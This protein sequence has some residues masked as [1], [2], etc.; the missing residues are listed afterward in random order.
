[1]RIA[2]HAT[3]PWQVSRPGRYGWLP[4]HRLPKNAYANLDECSTG[5]RFCKTERRSVCIEL[6]AG[7]DHRRERRG[8]D[9]LIVIAE[10]IHGRI[11]L[12]E[13]GAVER[14]T[15]IVDPTDHAR[16]VEAG[17]PIKAVPLIG[18]IEVSSNLSI[19]NVS[20]WKIG[21]KRKAEEW[22]R[23]KQPNHRRR[24]FRFWSPLSFRSESESQQQ[25][26]LPRVAAQSRIVVERRSVAKRLR[27]DIAET[28]NR[29]PPGVE[30][31]CRQR[32]G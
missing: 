1:V 32:V 14:M 6:L 19:A 26:P 8:N 15:F 17:R 11:D 4:C 13:P 16:P 29:D 2:S 10:V 25:L 22:N 5:F 9:S 7:P 3:P 31:L 24:H 28:R 18:Q 20:A 21:C 30:L 12:L 27:V 23:K